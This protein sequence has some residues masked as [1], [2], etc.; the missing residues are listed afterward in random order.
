MFSFHGLLNI[1]ASTTTRTDGKL[2]RR[3]TGFERAGSGEHSA[4]KGDLI[5]AAPIVFGR[6]HVLPI[7]IEF[8]KS[9]YCV[10]A[11]HRA[12]PGRA[13]TVAAVMRITGC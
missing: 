12:K 1:E 9:P 11:K 3:R 6:L 8:L 10:I 4:P 2:S 5:I 13:E 7:V